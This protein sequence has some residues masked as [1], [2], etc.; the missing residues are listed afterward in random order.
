MFS[1]ALTSRPSI[2]NVMNLGSGFGTSHYYVD[3]LKLYD[4]V[5]TQATQCTMIIGGSWTGSSCTLP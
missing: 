2:E 3:D 1:G 4:Q 5:Y